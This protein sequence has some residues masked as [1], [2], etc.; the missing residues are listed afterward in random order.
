MEVIR[1]LVHYRKKIGTVTLTG[2]TDIQR[3]NEGAVVNRGN[4]VYRGSRG[5]RELAVTGVIEQH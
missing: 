3:V 4:S 5:Y 2:V 1:I